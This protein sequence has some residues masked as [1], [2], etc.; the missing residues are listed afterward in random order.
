M[1]YKQT[2][3]KLKRKM[4]SAEVLTQKIKPEVMKLEKLNK[5]IKDIKDILLDEMEQ[6]NLNKVEYSGILSTVSA[7]EVPI[8]RKDKYEDFCKY[9]KRTGKFE[10]FTKRLNTTG[11][12][13]LFAN[14]DGDIKAM[15]AWSD[16]YINK[17][18]IVKET[19]K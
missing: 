3:T 6:E 15:P 5:E 10:L 14:D 19:K 4:K 17:K 18:V 12:K 13:E 11:F 7:T 8:I 2:I 16:I 1:S 9:V